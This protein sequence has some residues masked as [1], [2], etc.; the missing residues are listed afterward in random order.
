[1]KT[2]PDIQ[3]LEQIKYICIPINMWRMLK[4]KEIDQPLVIGRLENDND[5]HFKFNILI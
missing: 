1:M 4:E 5:Q 3:N 2:F